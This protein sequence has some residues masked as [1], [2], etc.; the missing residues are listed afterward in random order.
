MDA[1]YQLISY[2]EKGFTEK[3]HTLGV[4]FDLEKAYDTAW[5][6]EILISLH[7]VG[8]G[9]TYQTLLKTFSQTKNLMSG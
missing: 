6:T 5:W 4:F 3:K 2:V 7:S 8:L 9:V 1:F